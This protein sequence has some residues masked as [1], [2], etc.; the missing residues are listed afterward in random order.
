MHPLEHDFTVFLADA[1]HVHFDLDV[2][3]VAVGDLAYQAGGELEIVHLFD[4]HGGGYQVL[5]FLGDGAVGPASFV[6]DEDD[7]FGGR[8]LQEQ[9]DLLLHDFQVLGQKRPHAQR[10]HAAGHDQR[11]VVAVLQ[12]QFAGR[13]L[14]ES[15]LVSRIAAMDDERFGRISNT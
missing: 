11:D 1:R 3:A 12:T 14:A 13:E 7:A 6:I 9:F 2:P 8:V 4:A 15:L 5:E 10:G